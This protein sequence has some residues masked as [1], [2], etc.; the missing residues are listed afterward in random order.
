MELNF[1]NEVYA[2]IPIFGQELWITETNVST[3]AIMA[4]LIILAIVVRIKLNN[5]SE[6]PTGF[7]NVI[8]LLVEFMDNFTKDNMGE[9]QAGF[10][11]YF[12]GVFLFLLCANLCGLLGLRPP[13]ADLATT[14]GFALVTFLLI[15]I[16]GMVKQKGEYWKGFLHP[17]FLFLP[18]NIISTFATPVSLAGRMFGNILGGFIIIGLYYGLLPIFMKIGIP[19]VLHVYFDVF[20]GC[21]QAYI[22]VILSMTFIRE[23]IPE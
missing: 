11:A 6:K 12:F 23:K 10:G 8:E 17:I 20:A 5:F 13:T 19:V 7:Q 3:W 18:I 2:V 9:K 4:V 1:N 16:L 21:L 15:N 22:F 14:A